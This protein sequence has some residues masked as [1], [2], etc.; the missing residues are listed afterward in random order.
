MKIVQLITRDEDRFN[1]WKIKMKAYHLIF[2][3]ARL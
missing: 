3:T 1:L 2:N